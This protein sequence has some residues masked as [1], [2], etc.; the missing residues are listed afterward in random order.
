MMTLLSVTLPDVG[1][2]TGSDISVPINGSRNSSG[3]YKTSQTGK[4]R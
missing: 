4:T 2:V 3:A 1:K